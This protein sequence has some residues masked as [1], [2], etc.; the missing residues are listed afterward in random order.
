[1]KKQASKS[2]FE[3]TAAER[4][5]DVKQYDKP[6]PRSNVRPLTKAERERF[7]RARAGPVR[8]L[9]ASPAKKR[10][11]TLAVNEVLLAKMDRLAE[12]RGVTRE[13]II[14]H[15]FRTLLVAAL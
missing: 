13:Q 12:E 3:M 5:E 2:F 1:M 8:H 4:A 7:E 15:S 10:K 9:F 6:I 11:I 14:E